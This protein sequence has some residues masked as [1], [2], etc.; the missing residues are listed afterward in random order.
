M[1]AITK[2]AV[3]H[4]NITLTPVPCNSSSI[5]QYPDHVGRTGTAISPQGQTCCPVCTIAQAISG[6]IFSTSPLN[7]GAC[8]SRPT[9]IVQLVTSDAV[10]AEISLRSPQKLFIFIIKKHTYRIKVPKQNLI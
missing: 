4:G 10:L 8:L 7:A 9:S 3:K 5:E 6:P 2:D 1:A